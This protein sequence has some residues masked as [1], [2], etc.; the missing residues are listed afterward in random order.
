MSSSNS[1]F[2]PSAPGWTGYNRQPLRAPIEMS[3]EQQLACQVDWLTQQ[4]CHLQQQLAGGPPTIPAP[5]VGGAGVSAEQI[6]RWDAASRTVAT[7]LDVVSPVSGTVR[8][9]HG[10]NSVV[11]WSEV[12]HESGLSD[13]NIRVTP[14]NDIDPNIAVNYLDLRIPDGE[15]F[16]G[17][18]RVETVLPASLP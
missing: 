1:Y 2:P 9:R 17:K 15:T 14:A 6:A 5:G 7:V 3:F 8:L 4:V 10:L 18:I 12:R 11:L 16:V 13:T